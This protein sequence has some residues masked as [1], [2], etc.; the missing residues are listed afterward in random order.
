MADPAQKTAE[1][2]AAVRGRFM[3]ARWCLMQL[4]VSSGILGGIAGSALADI[5]RRQ[6][7]RSGNIAHMFTI[8]LIVTSLLFTLSAG[9]AGVPDERTGRSLLP[10][11]VIGAAVGIVRLIARCISIT[12]ENKMLAVRQ[13]NQTS[14]SL[15]E[16]LPSDANTVS[17]GWL[18]AYLDNVG[19]RKTVVRP[20]AAES[21]LKTATLLLQQHTS[22]E[23][24]VFHPVRYNTAL[25]R[26]ARRVRRRIWRRRIHSSAAV[27]KEP[28][29]G[30]AE[31]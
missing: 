11:L 31:R 17:Y 3:E 30:I 24:K 10:T 2:A 18:A 4:S 14:A 26:V 27:I 25:Q 6:R 5:Q 15:A 22:D 12:A 19:M 21:D 29:H 7:I 9:W 23:I 28:R 1:L 16:R 8:S 20:P 13:G